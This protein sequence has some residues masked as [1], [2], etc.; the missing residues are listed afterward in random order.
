MR[1]FLLIL[2]TGLISCSSDDEVPSVY[3]SNEVI[4]SLEA[5]SQFPISGTAT[6]KERTTGDLEFIIQ[7]NGT[8]GDIEHPVHLHYGDVSTPDAE[9]AAMLNPV[10]GETG[11]SITVFNK[12]GDET[13]FSFEYLE[14]FNGHIKVHQDSGPN[15][16]VILAYGNIG[17]ASSQS[18]NG[19]ISIAIC[20]S[21]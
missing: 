15:K 4:Y 11:Q 9:I 17:I 7:L 21:E 20:K 8:D 13:P 12:L 5:G 10:F 18:T 2:L 3:T 14:N 6:V 19:R 1:Y 16:D